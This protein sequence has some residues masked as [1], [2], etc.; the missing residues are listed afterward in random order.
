MPPLLG[1]FLSIGT[2][3]SVLA[4]TCAYLIAYHEYRQRMLLLTQNPKRMAL[5]T[6]VVTFVFMMVA[7]VV[8]YFALRPD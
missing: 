7:T 3:F 8:L 2:I 6:A 4:A 5:D 1:L